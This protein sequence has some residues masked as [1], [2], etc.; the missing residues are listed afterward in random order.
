MNVAELRLAIAELPD[1]MLVGVETSVDD[2]DLEGHDA[3]A[4]YVMDFTDDERGT[5]MKVF[6]IC[7]D[8]SIDAVDRW[9]K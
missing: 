7:V 1:D 3:T 5:G 2:G 9:S 4:A 6:L 8:R